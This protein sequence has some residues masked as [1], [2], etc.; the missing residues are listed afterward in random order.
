MNLVEDATFNSA[1]QLFFTDIQG[2]I[3]RVELQT[4][5]NTP[6]GNT[7]LGAS[8]LGIVEEPGSCPVA[9]AYCTPKLNSLGCT[10]AISSTGVAS[11]TAGSGF[12]IH[13][14]N[15]RNQKP[16]LLLYSDAGRTA[17]P[18]QGGV[19]CV[20]SPIKRSTAIN[21]GGTALPA[22]DCS[23]VYSLD[24]NL[25]AVGG[26]GGTPAPYLQVPGTVVDAQ[27]WG[28]DP[29]FLAPNNSTLTGGLEF[30]ICQ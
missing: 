14:S 13:G 5:V 6:V 9:S 19:R 7:G 25:F 4:G 1:G 24:M 15:V 11:A 17:V 30:T 23:G 22:S 12:L 8:L 29:G 20:N 27:I 16:G 3:H 2:S 18:F 10:P 26:L 28:R 21:S